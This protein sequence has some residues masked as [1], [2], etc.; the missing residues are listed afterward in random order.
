MKY[1]VTYFVKN[2]GKGKE[3]FNIIPYMAETI[4]LDEEE[5]FE[6]VASKLKMYPFLRCCNI[7]KSSDNN[8]NAFQLHCIMDNTHYKEEAFKDMLVEE[9]LTYKEIDDDIEISDL[10]K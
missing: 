1:F 6:V 10:S 3:I 5:M 4:S 9:S 2:I 8:R 7:M